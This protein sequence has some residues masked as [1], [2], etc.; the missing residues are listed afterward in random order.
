MKLII[1]NLTIK[2]LKGL[3]MYGLNIVWYGRLITQGEDVIFQEQRA[4]GFQAIYIRSCYYYF[5]FNN[6][7]AS[8]RI[9]IGHLP[10]KFVVLTGECRVWSDML[11]GLFSYEMKHK[12]YLRLR[13]TKLMRSWTL[14]IMAV[15]NFH[16]LSFTARVSCL[17]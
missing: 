17:R 6:L 10:G 12:I 8:L 11:T 13:K 4:N 15:I 14:N 5:E 1:C 16:L 7:F 9:S 3:K 2:S